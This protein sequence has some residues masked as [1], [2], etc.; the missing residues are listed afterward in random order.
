MKNVPEREPPKVCSSKIICSCIT[1]SANK[2]KAPLLC[3]GAFIIMAF[4]KSNVKKILHFVS[5]AQRTFCTLR[6]Q[7]RRNLRTLRAQRTENFAICARS[8][9]KFAHFA[10]AAQRT[11]WTLRTQ[12]K[13]NLAL[14]ARSTMKILQFAD[15]ARRTFC[16]LGA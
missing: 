11:F 5:A 8:A 1:F 2:I 7:R 10:R 16:I 12:H 6:A 4:C 13:E 15:A 14:S 3:C 9:K